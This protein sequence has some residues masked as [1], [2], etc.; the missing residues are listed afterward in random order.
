VVGIELSDAMVAELRAKPGDEAIPM[1]IGDMATPRVDGSFRLVYLV[2]NTIGNLTTQDAQV[3]CFANAAAHL[4]PGGSFVVEAGVPPLQR[5][6]EGD[7]HVV[8]AASVEHWAPGASTGCNRP[9]SFR[10]IASTR[11]PIDRLPGS[12]ARDPLTPRRVRTL[13]AA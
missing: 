12:G 5:L 4:E 7:R 1:T 3:D 6:P 11:L 8:F 13:H 2:F 10:A 9:Q